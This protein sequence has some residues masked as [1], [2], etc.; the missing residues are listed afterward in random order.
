MFIIKTLNYFDFTALNYNAFIFVP[1]A[2]IF[3][4]IVSLLLIIILKK[5]PVLK[6]FIT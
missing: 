4:Y 6:Q 1:I 3:V 2:S 5:I